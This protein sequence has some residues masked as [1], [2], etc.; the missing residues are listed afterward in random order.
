VPGFDLH[1]PLIASIPG[2]ERPPTQSNPNETLV[3]PADVRVILDVNDGSAWTAN[4]DGSI[5][6]YDESNGVAL[7]QVPHDMQCPLAFALVQSTGGA[8]EVWAARA[9]G[10]IIIFD[11]ASR[12]APERGCES[13][14]HTSHP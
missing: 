12:Q 1:D 10:N 11:R 2:G 5:G 9:D 4:R 8:C 14:F 7:S 13:L 6:V 3:V